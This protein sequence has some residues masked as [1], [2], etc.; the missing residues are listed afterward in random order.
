MSDGSSK[1]GI[2]LDKLVDTLLKEKGAATSTTETPAS[3]VAV[4][5]S[6]STVELA[7]AIDAP[8][9]LVSY[10]EE[11]LRK[12]R[13]R[14]SLFRRREE[15]LEEEEWADWGLTPIGHYSVENAQPEPENLAAP[16]QEETESILSADLTKTDEAVEKSELA[17][18]VS[19]EPD[20]PVMPSSAVDEFPSITPVAETITIPIPKVTLPE[21][22]QKTKVI[23]IKKTE[24][25]PVDMA[26]PLEEP[27][28]EQLPNQMSLEELVRV[29]DV[30]GESMPAIQEEESAEERFRRTRLEKIRDFTLDGEEEEV[31][32]PEEEQEVEPE[33]EQIIEDFTR[34]E[35]CKAIRLELQYR[36]RTATICVGLTAVLETVLLVLT[37]MTIHLNQSPITD[38][39]YLSVQVFAM[40]LI[41]VLN[42]SAVLH[43]ISGLFSLR[44]N[45]ESAPSL[46]LLTGIVA[47]GIHFINLSE[48][49]P[50]WTPLAGIPMLLLAIAQLVRIHRI[51]RNF[52]FI[53]H[54]GEKYSA[55]LI[56]EEKPLREISQHVVM[57]GVAQVA[58]FRRTTFLSDYLH[59]SYEEDEGDRW[60]R[61]LVPLS[62]LVSLLASLL[63]LAFGR[64]HGFWE[65][66]HTFV[67]I[68]CLSCAPLALAVQLPLTQCSRHML[69]HGGFIVGW[70]AVDTFGKP[71]A[72]VVDVSDLYFDE[73]MLLHGIKTFSGVHID[74]AILDAASLSIRSGG[75]LSLVFRRIIQDRMD[76]LHEVENLVYEQGMGLSGWV[77]GRRVLVGNR[78]LLSN[79]GV[80]VPSSDYEARYAK[81]GRR[82]VYLST[83]GELS[84]MFVV[85]YLPDE[86]VKMA[87]Q[88][89]CRAK[90][91]LLVRSC[92]PNVTAADLCAGFELDEYYVEVL[93]APAGR[94]YDQLVSEPTAH[95]SAV[96]ASNGHIVG[97]AEALSA[98]R[99]LRIKGR[100]ALI[101]SLIMA[102]IGVVLGAYWA[103]NGLILYLFP[104]LVAVCVSTVLSLLIPLFKRI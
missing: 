60:S 63:L 16:V 4:T 22:E 14:R 62:F 35:D 47:V 1:S 77:D 30:S 8:P 79:H 84:A 40:L 3:S 93:P 2:D 50:L 7:A 23:G 78:R 104:A 64:L 90:V 37:F 48:G 24:M 76:L 18:S 68:L 28:A 15:K 11:L 74:D 67:F 10:D 72:L 94:L 66:M 97:T 70:K 55:S 69:R 5:D 95:T 71:D 12:K 43:G 87:L 19:T 52:A 65:C 41:A 39:G 91:T 17:D 13:R 85:S 102:L 20:E 53:S 61:W 86:S 96:M 45:S 36:I 49:L 75:P 6:E 54:T 21:D 56:E 59:N 82:L 92:D 73:T 29:E 9:F 100:I 27:E 88:D 44:A 42:Y 83:A 57:N 103:V 51:R 34:Y 89:L 58:Y 101:V 31:N 38:I 99:S 33:E 25:T 80:D 46:T 32:E 26:L 81:N 98:C